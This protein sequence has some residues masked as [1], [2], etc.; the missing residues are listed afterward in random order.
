MDQQATQ[1]QV[2]DRASPASSKS[3]SPVLFDGTVIVKLER[4]PAS[5][6]GRWESTPFGGGIDSKTPMAVDV[7]LE[8][9]G[10]C[11]LSLAGIEYHPR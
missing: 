7:L 9:K 4:K 10:Q 6:L 5:F 8:M 2:I 1:R 3:I 11:N